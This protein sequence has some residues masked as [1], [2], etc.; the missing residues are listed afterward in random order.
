[1][2]NKPPPTRGGG[3]PVRVAE[4]VKIAVNEVMKKLLRCV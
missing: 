2:T 1:M 3:A 4:A